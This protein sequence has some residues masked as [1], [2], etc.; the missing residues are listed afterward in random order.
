MQIG[1]FPRLLLLKH[2][3]FVAAFQQAAAIETDRVFEGSIITTHYG[4]IKG[5]NIYPGIGQIEPKCRRSWGIE[6]S[7]LY[8]KGLTQVR[9]TSTQA[10]VRFRGGTF[11]PEN[12]GKPFAGNIAIMPKHEQ[13]KQ[14]LPFAGAQSWQRSAVQMYLK[15][16]KEADIQR[17]SLFF[18]G[19][20][21][22]TTSSRQRA[23]KIRA[24]FTL[25]LF[26]CA[27][28]C[29]YRNGILMQSTAWCSPIHPSDG[30]KRPFCLTLPG[31]SR[32]SL[33]E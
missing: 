7:R 1:L 2:P 21:R 31:E 29:A 13:G 14:P 6:A 17:R 33:V 27:Y 9:Q 23:A 20:H 19:R 8:A 32:M 24:D 5:D 28:L 10:I 30:S 4:C 12:T 16:S 18:Q 25:F 15:R 11:R 22:R 3:C 26:S